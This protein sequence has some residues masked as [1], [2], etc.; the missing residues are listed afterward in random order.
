GFPVK[1]RNL[2]WD[3]SSR[4]LATDGGSAVCLWDCSDPGPEG[5]GPKI[6]GGENEEVLI[7]ALAY[8]RSGPL[9]ASGD[10]SGGLQLWEPTRSKQPLVAKQGPF[11]VTKLAWSPDDK[12]LAAAD[13][14]GN[15]ACFELLP[16]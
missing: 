11:A 5:R 1:V 2:A 7:S 4:Y 12:R 13:E 8:Q 3:G 10:Q 14:H 16:G 6:L 15:V 9:L